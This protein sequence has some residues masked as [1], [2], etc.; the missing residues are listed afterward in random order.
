MIDRAW[1]A[2]GLA[3]LLSACAGTGQSDNRRTVSPADPLAMPVPEFL[4]EQRDLRTG[5]ERGLPRQLDDQEW[6]RL[7]RIHATFDRILADVTDINQVSADDRRLLYHLHAEVRSMVHG[8]HGDIVCHRT[9]RTGTR[10]GAMNYCM[11]RERWDEG[12][13]E[14]REI[15]RDLEAQPRRVPGT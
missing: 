12:R 10:H 7:N 4:I 5:L 15:M 3:M 13:R 1:L 2:L 14:A 6:D 11:E 9:H 8:E